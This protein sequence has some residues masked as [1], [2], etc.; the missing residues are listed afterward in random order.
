MST[1][2]ELARELTGLV[3]ATPGVQEVY[4]GP[5][6]LRGEALVRVARSGDGGRVL[7]DICVLDDH[8]VPGT[9]RL[10][11][12]ALSARLAAEPGHFEVTVKASRIQ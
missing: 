5:G 9:L 7:A 1:D 11:S 4:P 8:P 3:L 2:T 6:A 12:R 10:V